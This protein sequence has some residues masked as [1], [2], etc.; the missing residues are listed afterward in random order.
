MES[1]DTD[2]TILCIEGDVEGSH[3]NEYHVSLEY[4]LDLDTFTSYQCECPAYQSYPGMCKHCAALALEYLEERESSGT[5]SIFSLKNT[6]HQPVHR[7][8]TDNRILDLVKSYA[9]QKRMNEQKP[10]GNI[11]IIPELAEDG[12]YY[13]SDEHR[14][15]LSFQIGQADGRKYVL[16]NLT[17]FVQNVQ[18]EEKYTYGKLLSFVHSKSMFTERGWRYV[19]LIMQGI[20]EAGQ[21]YQSVTKELLLTPKLLEEFF[22]INR[23]QDISY[24]SGSKKTVSLHVTEKNP[25]LKLQV[26]PIDGG[27][28]LRIPA[29]TILSG[30]SRIF[31]NIGNRIY[32]CTDEYAQAMSRVLKY[33]SSDRETVCNISESDMTA[34]CA[35]VLPALEQ[36]NALDTASV[37]LDAYQPKQADIAFYLDEENGRVTLKPLCSYGSASYQ[38]LDTPELSSEYHDR[39]REIRAMNAARA[40]FPY[41]DLQRKVLYFSSDDLDR[42]YQLL[43]TGIM[44][45]GE[46]GTVYAS[47]KIKNRN[48]I[49][50]PR[51][52]I[53]VSLRGGLL[54]LSVSSD[55]FTSGELADILDRYQKK[56][57]YYRLENGDFLNLEGNSVTDVAELLDGLSIPAKELAQESITVPKF[58]ACYVDQS[59]RQKSGQLQVERNAGYK[60]ILRDMKNVEDS[61]YQVPDALAGVLRD[62]QKTG[63]RWLCT[64]ADLG[65]GGILADDMGL[66]KTLQAITYLLSR[67]YAVRAEAAGS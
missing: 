65:F 42:M 14:Y 34:F 12:R 49:R 6:Q 11:E 43:D 53:G 48:I 16:R 26:K 45:L 52:Q 59:L 54:E 3:W 13:Y 44:Q 36:Q 39:S 24:V 66:G 51:A 41:E 33:A 20:S 8:T 61:D 27:F 64:L 23:D 50:S 56:K 9:L 21:H 19:Q 40:Y 47:E 18:K 32:C 46:E 1:E 15:I 58:R 28:Q 38:L 30:A 57:K 5:A 67:K 35:S 31:I 37:S 29:L 55:A 17:D 63:Y 2:G 25:P 62:Y 10:V 7:L 4:N 22:S 60:A